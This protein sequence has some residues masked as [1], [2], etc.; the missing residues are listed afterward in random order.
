MLVMAKHPRK[1]IHSREA[2]R[3]SNNGLKLTARGA[4]VEARQLNP[5]LGGGMTMEQERSKLGP[6]RK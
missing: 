5:V 2:K 1:A 3:P 6:C 4:S